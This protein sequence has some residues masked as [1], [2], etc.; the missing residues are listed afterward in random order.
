MV[1]LYICPP[2]FWKWILKISIFNFLNFYIYSLKDKKSVVLVL[3]CYFSPMQ[4]TYLAEKVLIYCCVVWK[5][6]GYYYI[7]QMKNR[8]KEYFYYV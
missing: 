3:K 4:N 1:Y 6:L 5:D 2:I 7:M 8:R